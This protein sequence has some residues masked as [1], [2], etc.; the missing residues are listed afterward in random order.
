VDQYLTWD[1][2]ITNIVKKCNSSMCQLNRIRNKL[3]P[4]IRKDLAQTLVLSHLDYCSPVWGNTTAKNI[5]RLQVVQ[6]RA[7]RF[8]LGCDN[9]TDSA[10][11]LHILGWSP[12]KE[13]IQQ[14]SYATFCK[15]VNTGLPKPLYTQLTFQSTNSRYQTRSTT[16][17]CIKL[18]KPRT[19]AERKRF[20]YRM[21]CHWNTVT[22]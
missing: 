19:N 9:K 7:A 13:R 3:P 20:L 14:R 5:K 2:H 22:K 11:R 6:N 18:S 16:T 15:I 8:A 21:A 1:V 12:V 17:N 4:R 10:T